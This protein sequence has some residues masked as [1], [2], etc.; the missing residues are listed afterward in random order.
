MTSSFRI[1]AVFNKFWQAT[2]GRITKIR[3]TR[4]AKHGA[5]ILEPNLRIRTTH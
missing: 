4:F 1:P 2:D 3:E 5:G